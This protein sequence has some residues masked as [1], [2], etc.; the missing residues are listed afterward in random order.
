[1]RKDELVLNIYRM[2]H[3]RGCLVMLVKGK[4]PLKILHLPDPLRFAGWLKQ[5]SIAIDTGAAQDCWYPFDGM[6]K[7]A[8]L[9]K[10]TFAAEVVGLEIYFKRQARLSWQGTARELGVAVDRM[11][12]KLPKFF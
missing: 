4:R 5:L 8:P 6:E 10:C 7:A 3:K 12:A 2:D 1:M 9:L 11:I